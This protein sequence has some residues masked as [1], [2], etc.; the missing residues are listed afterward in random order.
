MNFSY[1]V[2]IFQNGNYHILEK[3]I[4]SFFLSTQDKCTDLQHQ[5]YNK[6][7]EPDVNSLNDISSIIVSFDSLAE[8]SIYIIN[9][10]IFLKSIKRR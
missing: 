3:I 5:Y 9:Q 10:L 8:T 7:I 2:Y 6:T 4:K 1:H